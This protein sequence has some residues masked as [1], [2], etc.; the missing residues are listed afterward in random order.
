VALA[1]GMKNPREFK[2]L[3]SVVKLSTLAFHSEEIIQIYLMCFNK[4]EYFIF[5]SDFFPI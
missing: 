5:G 3:V 4:V 2:G 1:L